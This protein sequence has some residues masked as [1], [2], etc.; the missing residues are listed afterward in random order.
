M[1]GK[2]IL[3]FLSAILLLNGNASN[4]YAQKLRL[5][6][7]FQGRKH[8][9]GNTTYYIDPKKGDDENSGATI[10]NPWKTFIRA[11]QL[12]FSAGDRLKIVT[13]GAFHQ[14]LVIMA[15][16]NKACPVIISFAPG[17][18]DFYPDSSYKTRFN[19]SNTNDRP[20]DLKAIALYFVNSKYVRFNALGAKVVLRGKMI[21]ACVDKSE[22]IDIHGIS[23]DY[24]RPTVSELKVVKVSEHYADLQVHRD[25]KYSIKD[26]LLTWEGEGWR[27]Q[28]GW[29]WQIFYPKTGDL[30]RLDMDLS[31]VKFVKKGGTL[32]AFF[33]QNPGF[34]MGLI[35]Q[36]RD[37]TRDCAGI[38]MQ[39]SKNVLLNNIHI[40]FM[41]GMGIVSQF[42]ENI[43]IDSLIVKPDGKSGR[44]CSAWADILH[45]SGCRGMIEVNHSYL[46]AA[47]DDAINVHGTYL[48]IIGN[49]CPKQIKV[50][51]MHNQTYGFDAFKPGDSIDFI[52]SASLLPFGDNI[53]AATKKLNDKD[54]LLTLQY[55]VPPDIMQDEVVENISWT[56]RVWVHN[57]TISR[58]PT[59]GIL[60][61]TRQKAVIENCVFQNVHSSGILVEDDAE[62]WYESGRVRDLTISKNNFVG[63]GEPVICI[64]PENKV[65]E[66]PVHQ[67]ILVIGNK[68]ILKG[69][70]AMSAKSTSGI[71]FSENEIKTC[72]VLNIN[73][74]IELKDC[75]IIKLSGN[76]ISRR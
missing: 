53:I 30:S 71:S 49:P 23:F 64:H 54:I 2:S 68:F 25:S 29:Y 55:P 14:S 26:S 1:K 22:N 33:A 67:N 3:L 59:R 16:G 9:P 45:F 42:C 36:T 63:C 39:R 41:H 70:C 56:P 21:E 34:K 48:K 11:N 8:S 66:G 62:S 61:T 60:V 47:N 46:S 19:I 57:T 65:D 51:F 43:S 74:L 20:S 75:Q 28:S 58:I 4:L 31:K 24:K 52:H 27:Y 12:I 5:Y 50:R 17:R 18:Y 44:T 76:N 7:S 38:F 6:P 40:R 32:R 35:Y 72:K 10:K 37:V 13:P 73:A 15:G 69:S